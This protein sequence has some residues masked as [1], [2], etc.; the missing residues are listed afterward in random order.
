V[1]F[2]VVFSVAF[3]A[4]LSVAFRVVLSE[5]LFMF[6]LNCFVCKVNVIKKRESILYPGNPGNLRFPWTNPPSF[7]KFYVLIIKG[8]VR[9]REP[10]VPWRREGVSGGTVGSLELEKPINHSFPVS[11]KR[12][13][14]KEPKVPWIGLRE[15]A[16][17]GTVGSLEKGASGGTLGFLD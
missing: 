4:V 6:V 17:G 10:P 8:R 2:R 5:V 13:G 16:S 1:A 15:G 9:P 11:K 14:T 3:R 7:N 12:G